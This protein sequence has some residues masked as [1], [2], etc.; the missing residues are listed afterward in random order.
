VPARGSLALA[1]LLVATPA[2]AECP[3]GLRPAVVAELLLGRNIGAREGV[4]ET[5]FRSFLAREVMPR[6]PSGFSVLDMRGAYR[7]PK[8]G[9]TVAERGKRIS[10]VTEDAARDLPRL[11]EVGE[12]YRRRFQQHSVG[13]VTLPACAAF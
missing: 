9:R 1:A 11:R 2:R 5:A 7:D 12:A 6:F 3:E 4:T 8:T 13:L 10:V